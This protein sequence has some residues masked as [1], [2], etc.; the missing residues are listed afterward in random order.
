[1]WSR[2]SASPV[3]PSEE[4]IA[5]CVFLIGGQ[6]HDQLATSFTHRF[7]QRV[8]SKCA[9]HSSATARRIHNEPQLGDVIRPLW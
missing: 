1:M 7:D 4:N 5:K 6:L 8:A 9:T 2:S 3:K